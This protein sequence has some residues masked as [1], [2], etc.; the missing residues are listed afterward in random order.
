MGT[1][2]W[3][4]QALGHILV[5]AT[6]MSCFLRTLVKESPSLSGSEIELIG[7]VPRELEEV[8]QSF[9]FAILRHCQ[10]SHFSSTELVFRLAG[11][12]AR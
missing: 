1:L 4:C 8:Q 2:I 6:M 7:D 3:T 10:V 12:V 11:T 9:F 5:S